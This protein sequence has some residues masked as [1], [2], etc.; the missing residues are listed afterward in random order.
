[1]RS[2][3]GRLFGFVVGL[4]L[5]TRCFANPNG[6]GHEVIRQSFGPV[7]VVVGTADV[8]RDFTGSGTTLIP[9]YAALSVLIVQFDLRVSGQPVVV[10]FDAFAGLGDPRSIDIR[11]ATSR[12]AWRLTLVGGD[13][14]TSY[15]AVMEFDAVQVHAVKLFRNCS[16]K[17][18][19]AAKRYSTLEVLN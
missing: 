13:A 3:Q 5:A 12:N 2:I 1:M 10:P 9:G 6:G 8:P 16:A 7:S 15:C 18:P 11:K 19:F 17:A 14:S 4:T